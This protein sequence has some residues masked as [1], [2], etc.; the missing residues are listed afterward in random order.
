MIFLGILLVI[1]WLGLAL[2]AGGLFR[3]SPIAAILAFI[4]SVI[5]G[6]FALQILF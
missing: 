6:T 5:A 4:A 1:V 2:L 3:E